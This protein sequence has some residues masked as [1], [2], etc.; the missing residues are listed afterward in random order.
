MRTLIEV[1]CEL[2]AL[3]TILRFISFHEEKLLGTSGVK[4]HT[5]LRNYRQHHV[6]NRPFISIYTS[7]HPRPFNECHRVLFP[8]RESANV[9]QWTKDMENIMQDMQAGDTNNDWKSIYVKQ[10]D[11]LSGCGVFAK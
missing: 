5:L 9:R 11:E 4:F 6:C 8:Q 3:H 1:T 2:E 7:L 10:I